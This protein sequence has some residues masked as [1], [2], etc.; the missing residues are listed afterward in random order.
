MTH[1]EKSTGEVGPW[2]KNKP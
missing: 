2:R 1:T